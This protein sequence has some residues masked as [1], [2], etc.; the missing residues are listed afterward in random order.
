MS[1]HRWRRAALRRLAAM[2][3]CLC[4]I[5]SPAHAQFNPFDDLDSDPV[6]SADLTADTNFGPDFATT[7]A[8][9]RIAELERQLQELRASVGVLQAS[10]ELPQAPPALEF[11]EPTNYFQTPAAGASPPPSPV[12]KPAAPTP[13][14]Y[15]VINVSGVMQADAVWF[16][17]DAAS[18]A[19]LGDVEDFGGFRR[20]RLGVKGQLAENIGYQMEYDFGFPGR[21]NFTNVFVELQK[22]PGIGTWRVGQWKHPIHMEAV[23]SIRELIFMERSLPFGAFI[24]FR[25]IGTGLFNTAI[26][27]HLTWAI[28]GYRY[29]TSPF[30]NDF[31]D[32][33]YGWAG[34]TTG[35]LYNDDSI[36]ANVHI[37]GG[38]SQNRPST[39]RLRFRTNPEVGMANQDFNVAAFPLPFFVDTGSF[40]S[41]GYELVDL[42]FAASIYSALFVSEWMGVNADQEL[43]LPTL[44]FH[45]GYAEFAYVL[46]GE[47]R[48]YNKKTGVFTRVVPKNPY[49]NG[50]CGAWE[51]AGRWSYVDLNDQNIQGGRQHDWTFGLNW[52]PNQYTRFAFNYIHCMVDAPITGADVNADIFGTRAQFDF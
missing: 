48:P 20:A 29:P 31:G 1:V 16:D 33:G 42:E 4:G 3:V 14:K 52:F 25:Q 47:H 21:P 27:D 38:F 28:S 46:T 30:G 34:R 19:A 41:N 12:P 36:N 24:P 6:V 23:W 49:G 35:L 43:G 10:G 22:L 44:N 7:T 37:G 40:R 18:M 2:V 17:Q 50:S 39:D 51:L 13:I 8:D 26:D 5:S 11:T 9:D 45:G 15:P 32:D